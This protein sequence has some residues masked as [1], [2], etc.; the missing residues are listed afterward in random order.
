MRICFVASTYPRSEGDTAVPWLREDRGHEVHVFAPSFKG[1]ATHT[2]DGV[3]VHR[4]RYFFAAKEDLTH[5]A[6]APTKIR[7]PDYLLITVFY[8]LF[9][10]I[11]MYRLHRR[12]KFDLLHVHWPFPHGLFGVVARSG[13]KVPLVMSFHGAELLLAN[14]FKFVD[15]VLRFF[16][17]RADLVTCNS[18]Y[19]AS[20]IRKLGTHEPIILPYGSP[21]PER[22][23][24][25]PSNSVKTI[26]FVGRLI[27]RK[28]VEYL[29]RALPLV[30]RQ[31][32]ARLVIVG[33]G[34]L[35]DALKR[36]VEEAGLGSSVEFRVDVPEEELVRSYEAC[37]VFVLP[38]IVDSRGDTEGLGVVLIEALSFR[39]PVVA[40][41]VGGIV[42]VI[43][44]GETGYLVPEKDSQ[45]LAAKIVQSLQN[46]A[47]SEK[48]AKQGYQHV[49]RYYSWDRIIDRTEELY[50]GVASA[51]RSSP[52]RDLSSFDGPKA[53]STEPSEPASVSSSA[54]ASVPRD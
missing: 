12:E 14:K 45:A 7:R 44:D 39:R 25:L 33:N 28:G 1:S 37:D 4:F 20:K 27:E 17:R 13:Y 29:I 49:Q 30:Q 8:I 23:T 53:T 34:V 42:D 40:S 54:T 35:L 19:T 5:D 16:T 51:G 36:Q 18:S 32:D 26:L 46:R 48:L 3:K 24:P 22:N 15:P 10:A 31:V 21:V 47:E 43:H 6:G 50:R 41:A 38:A 9:G 2:V 11:G 52:N